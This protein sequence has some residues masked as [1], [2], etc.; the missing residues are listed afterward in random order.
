MRLYPASSRGAARTLAGDL[1]VVVLLCLFAW[2]GLKVHDAIAELA[3][4]GRGIQ[5]SGR[6]LATT[7]RDTAGAVDGAFSGA[8]GQVEGLPLVGGDLAAALRDAPKGATGPLREN[9]DEQGA[10]IV[11]LGAEQVRR[12][13]QLAELL[14]WLTFLPPA[15]VLLAWRLPPR[16]RQVARMT[17]A[18]RTLAGAPEHVL[19]A[20][21]AYN[22]PYRALARHTRDPFG[23]LEAGRHAGLL[24]A[25]AEDA[26]TTLPR[27]PP[28]ST[29]RSP[30]SA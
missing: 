2:L 18:R 16:A 20:R 7:T 15:L 11:R 26:G 3:V 28:T 30:R 9:G 4:V 5:D 8:A 21:A 10:R 24:A 22:L 12:T 6:A 14:G 19:A 13:N 23:D 1:T 25:L 17:T 29:S 27:R